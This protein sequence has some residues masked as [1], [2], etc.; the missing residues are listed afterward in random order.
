MA[1]RKRGVTFLNL[2]QK[3]GGTQ[4]GRGGGGGG[5]RPGGNY[6]LYKELEL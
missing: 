3:E 6:I 1:V 2:L 4:K 5:S